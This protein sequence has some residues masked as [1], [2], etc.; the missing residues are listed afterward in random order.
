[1]GSV[2]RL[3]SLREFPLLTMCACKQLPGKYAMAQSAAGTVIRIAVNIASGNDLLADS[4]TIAAR[5]EICL[6]CEH[7]I[8]VR[9]GDIVR[10]RCGECGCWL[11]RKLPLSKWSYQ[12]AS[13]CRLQ[14]W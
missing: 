13:P 10:H 12:D 14:R 5:R 4:A 1:M 7:C 2:R 8:T 3:E 9:Q 6:A 11:D